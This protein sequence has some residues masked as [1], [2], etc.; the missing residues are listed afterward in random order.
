[1]SSSHR[2]RDKFNGCVMLLIYV[3]YI[4]N[5]SLQCLWLEMKCYENCIY[6]YL[7]GGKIISITIKTVSRQVS[8]C[9]IFFHTTLVTTDKIYVC[10]YIFLKWNK[11]KISTCIEV[12]IYYL[13][14]LKTGKPLVAEQLKLNNSNC[15]TGKHVTLLRSLP[16]LDDLKGEKIWIFSILHIFATKRFDIVINSQQRIFLRVN[17][18]YLLTMKYIFR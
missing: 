5:F 1:M 10:T 17:W 3:V 2:L 7:S 8:R 11:Q 12:I 4:L 16:C 14:G 18:C 15:L 6:R 13:H 9:N